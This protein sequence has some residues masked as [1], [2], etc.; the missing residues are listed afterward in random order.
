MSVVASDV[1][2]TKNLSFPKKKTRFCKRPGSIQG[3]IKYDE[4]EWRVP[5][6]WGIEN[7]LKPKMKRHKKID[8]KSTIKLRD[9]QIEPYNNLA[10]HL[11]E[12]HTY[13]LQVPCG[14][15]KTIMATHSIP[16]IG[17]LT[18][19]ILP[20][21]NLLKQW[22]QV[23]MEFLPDAKLFVLGK[24]NSICLKEFG[25]KD[26]NLV[27]NINDADI[28]LS[29]P[30]AITK[31]PYEDLRKIGYVICDEARLMCTE[32]IL[33][34]I[35]H[36]V[37]KYLLGLSA[38]YERQDNMHIIMDKLFGMKKHIE[39]SKKP[40]IVHK[41]NTP[42]SP[43]VEDPSDWTQVTENLAKNEDINKEICKII[44]N[45]M[46]E[47]DKILVLCKRTFHVE[48]MEKLLAE[49]MDVETLYKDKK[50]YKNCKLLIGTLKK[51]GVGFDGKN[52]C[53]QDYDNIPFN[54]LHLCADIKEG[55]EQPAGRVGR[56]E[57]PEIFDYVHN[58]STLRKHWDVREKWYLSR[59]GEIKESFMKMKI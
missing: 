27:K 48:I 10:K 11:A 30:T 24:T 52:S 56:S 9:T 22:A 13:F 16:L 36:T 44:L 41:I 35:L 1:K 47:D 37:P 21:Y 38:D 32:K 50:G 12:Y 6:A 57:N 5:L 33:H 46:E 25:I 15:G 34:C 3:W 7:G 58:M 31:L 14:S 4:N 17:L 18:L 45:N 40:F 8:I 55:I 26:K 42:F 19:V 53:V 59:N 54:K 39:I 51:L 29:L 20:D 49:I 43:N 2:L 23:F 28:I